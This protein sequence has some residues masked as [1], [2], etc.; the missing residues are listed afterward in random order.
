MLIEKMHGVAHSFIGK[1]IFALLP[2]SFLIGGMSGY[3]Y[4]GN[5]YW[6][7]SRRCL[8]C[9]SFRGHFIGCFHHRF[10]NLCHLFIGVKSGHFLGKKF[11]SKAEIF[12]G[13]VLLLMA[14]KILHEHGVF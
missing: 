5:E 8:F 11:K 7:V 10:N 13:L 14:V 3:L 4:G 9:F 2:V 1:A 12:G 6:C